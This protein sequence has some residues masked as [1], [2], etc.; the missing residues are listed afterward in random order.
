MRARTG[1][2]V[3]GMIVVALAVASA[4]V[5]I[6]AGIGKQRASALARRAASAR[7]ERLG[8]TYPPNAWKA[9]CDPRTPGG[10]RCMVGTGGQWSGLV[11]VTGTSVRPRVRNVDVSCFE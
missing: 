7:V 3:A 6:A 11:T 2:A 9:A 5:A 10:W 8:I 1:R 4:P